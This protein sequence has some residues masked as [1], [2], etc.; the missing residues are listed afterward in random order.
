MITLDVSLLHYALLSSLLLRVVAVVA[1][2]VV[3]LIIDLKARK[4][5]R[6]LSK[7]LDSKL[8]QIS[9]FINGCIVDAGKSEADINA[10]VR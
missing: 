4:S 1:I 2:V 8:E 9:C 10:S 3:I 5:F 6:R 7:V